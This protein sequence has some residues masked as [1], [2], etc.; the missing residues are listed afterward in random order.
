MPD[1]TPRLKVISVFLIIGFSLLLQWYGRSCTLL[2]TSDSY[3]YLSAARSFAIG[4]EFR[5]PD[6][7][8][9]EF[10]PPLF[11]VVLSL[12][13]DPVE[14]IH[15]LNLLITVVAGLILFRLAVMFLKDGLLQILFLLIA[16]CSVYQIM[17]S[18]FLWTELLFLLVVLIHFWIALSVKEGG[19]K[20]LFLIV[21][22]FLFCLQRSAGIFFVIAV[23]SWMLTAGSIPWIR[24]VKASLLFFVISVSGLALWYGYVKSLKGDFNVSHFR[25]LEDPF[26]NLNAIFFTLGKGFVSGPSFLVISSFVC[27]LIVAVITLWK[28][29]RMNRSTQFLVWVIALYVLPFLLLGRLDQ[30]EMDRYFSVVMPFMFL[31]VFIAYDR[32]VVRFEK[33]R[34]VMLLIIGLWVIYPMA[35]TIKNTRMWHIRSCETEVKNYFYMN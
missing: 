25:F 17:I 34:L 29:L 20:T 16:L 6:G 4:G 2:L 15:F 31:F 1:R 33:Y 12:T 13:S 23:S 22:A 9:Y 30:Y 5:S 19:K 24:R 3:N 11:P 32:L 28:E 7:S 8:Y 21:T 26:Y 14:M 35:R 27:I 18:V 10:W